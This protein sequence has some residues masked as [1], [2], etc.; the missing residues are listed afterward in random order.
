MNGCLRVILG[1]QLSH[2][3][4]SL[5]DIDAD[6]DLIWM[7]E[8]QEEATYV[9]HHKK[10]IAYIFSAMRHFA[11]ELKDK[12]FNVHYTKLD[13]KDNAG[14]FFG[15]VERAIETHSA[16]K[17]IIAEAGEYRVMEDIKSWA[18]N[19]DVDVDIRDD[20]RFLATHDMFETWIEDRKAPR[21]EHFYREMRKKYDVLMEAGEPVGGK[22]NY[23]SENQKPPEEGLDIPRPYTANVDEITQEVLYL[24]G[25]RFD[26]HFGDLEPFHFA[27]TR[28][29]AL[30]CLRK[31]IDERLC[32]FGTYQDA[33]VEGEPWM[34]HSH[35]SFYIN[36]GLLKPLECIHAAEK[37][38][39]ED[40]VPLNAVE[41]FIRQILGWREYVRGIYWHKMPEYKNENFLDAKQ[42]LPPLYWGKKTHMNCLAQCV[43]ETKENAYAHHIQRLMVLGNFSLIAGIKPEEVNEWYLLVYADA[44]QW[45]ELP[46]V[47]GMVL[48]ADGG[49]LASKPYAS[50]GSY[51]NKMSDYCKGC[52]YKVT[53]KNG[54]EA[55]PFNY[56][57][58]NFLIRNKDKLKSNH[59]LG[60]MY[61]TL[62]RMSD[63]KI[64]AI[65]DDSQRFLKAMGNGDIV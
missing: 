40:D 45:V 47:T 22:W 29:Q 11:Q 8:V 9:K 32:N 52:K 62:G 41:G 15:E 17:V 53:K 46:N 63:D 37:A 43:K 21:M 24:V 59:R 38:Y 14:S 5:S 34:Y 27:V 50:S 55:C 60:M 48:F 31:F 26:E 49:L 30:Y 13:D 65:Q 64:Q 3:I 58:W 35:I 18:E 4:S 42:E 54:P 25:E 61:G 51:I 7:C 6:N 44:Y 10:K 28:D 1:D 36:S 19:F 23:D 20:D 16:D 57:Y 2:D 12:G 33:M 39:H 56:L